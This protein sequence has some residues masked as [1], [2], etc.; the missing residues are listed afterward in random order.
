ML[1]HYK[2]NSCLG[3]KYAG[4]SYYLAKK[5]RLPRVCQHSY[6]RQTDLGKQYGYDPL[7]RRIWKEQYRDAN[8]IALTKPKRTI[9]LYA[10]EGLIAEATQAITVATNTSGVQT[11]TASAAPQIT[12]QYGPTPNSP[13]GTGALFIKTKNSNNTDTVAYYH[14]DHLQTPIQATDK[15]GNI[16]WAA[17]YDAFGKAT[18]I[19]PAATV[20]KP[21]IESNLR[22]PGQYEDQETG[23]HYNYFRYM[24]TQTGRYITQDPIGLGGGVNQ[25]AY[26]DGNP[27]G[28]FDPLGLWSQ[29]AHDAIIKRFGDGQGFNA[30]AIAAMQ[31][32]SGP[33]GADNFFL[34][35]GAE[36]AFMHAMSSSSMDKSTSCSLANDF[37]NKYLS[38]YEQNMKSAKYWEGKNKAYENLAIRDA[39]HALGFGLHAVMDAS[40]PVHEGFQYWHDKRHFNFKQWFSHGHWWFPSSHEDKP[41]DAQM[42]R[43]VNDMNQAMKGEYKFKCPPRDHLSCVN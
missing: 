16:V 11:V 30:G 19:T 40:S 33:N 15:A 3:N 35:Q 34:Y 26:V 9:Y 20:D 38:L 13:F 27:V 17:S 22:L 28:K 29:G 41:T 10:D 6:K 37:L 39:Y 36:S 24:D 5:I 12:T 43:A 23:L 42:N 21:T 2:Y 25:F 8:A 18:I 1:N 4:Y 31:R 14:H 7:G 32:G